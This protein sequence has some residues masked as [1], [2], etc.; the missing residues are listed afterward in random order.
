MNNQLEPFNFEFDSL[1]IKW[2]IRALS[3][4]HAKKVSELVNHS[5]VGHWSTINQNRIIRIKEQ[6]ICLEDLSDKFC[7]ISLKLGEGET[8]SKLQ[9]SIPV[10]KEV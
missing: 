2:V 1:D 6:L 5:V 9:C 3:T 7:A 10:T 4:F 8:A